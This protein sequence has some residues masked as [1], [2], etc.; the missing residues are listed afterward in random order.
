MPL[1]MAFLT[2]ACGTLFFKH[3][4]LLFQNHCLWDC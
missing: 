1:D 2:N 4:N 3:Q